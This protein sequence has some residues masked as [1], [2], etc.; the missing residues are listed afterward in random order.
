MV[1]FSI[2]R[3]FHR[4]RTASFA[5]P[6]SSQASDAYVACSRT[7]ILVNFNH[8]VNNQRHRPKEFKFKIREV[9][10]NLRFTYRCLVELSIA[11]QH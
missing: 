6:N 5:N 11:L 4:R 10:L 2:G 7:W 8:V 3:K 1:L 9:T